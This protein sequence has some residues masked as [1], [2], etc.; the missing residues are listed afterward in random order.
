[1]DIAPGINASGWHALKL[2]DANSPDWNRAVEILQQRVTA[3]YID[4]ADRLLQND[5]SKPAT[6][7][8]FG[9]TILALDCLLVET[10]QAFIVASPISANP[11]PFTTHGAL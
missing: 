7:R 6:K 8:R 11:A 3:R 4:P 10:L 5:S 9:F 2:D 1:M